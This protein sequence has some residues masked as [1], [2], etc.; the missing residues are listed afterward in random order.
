[1]LPNS[2]YGRKLCHLS[3]KYVGIQI[4]EPKWSAK[5]TNSSDKMDSVFFNM[6]VKIL[7]TRFCLGLE[8][9][10]VS[11]KKDV[12]FVGLACT[13]ICTV[14][15]RMYGDF[16]AKNNVCTPYLPINVKFWPTLQKQDRLWF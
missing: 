5:K 10:G 3:I 9:A 11:E 14:Y 7:P 12:V 13:A 1:M 6:N 16:P 15:D 4:I 8:D 2:R